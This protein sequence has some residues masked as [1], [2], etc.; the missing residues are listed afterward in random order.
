MI[1]QH[2][3]DSDEISIYVHWPYCL[4]KCP[5]CDFNSH[6]IEEINEA[7]WISAYKNEF[8]YFSEILKGKYIKSIF[9]GGGT[10]SLMPLS[11]LDSILTRISELAIIDEHTEI[12]LEANPSSVEQSKFQNIAKLGVNRISIGVQSFND[13]NLKFLGRAHSSKEAI[14]A[15]SVAQQYFSKTSFDLIY[16]LPNQTLNDWQIELEYAMQY[17][18]G[19]ISLYQLTIEKGT[20]FYKD[21]Q[22]KE[23]QLPDQSISEE[24]YIF[25]DSFLREKDIHKYEISNYSNRNKECRHNLCYWN[26][27]NYIGV[28][29]GAHSR[30]SF[31]NK[32]T[33]A[34]MMKNNPKSW[35]ESNLNSKNGIQNS[36]ILTRE[37]LLT[38]I[39]MM[40]LRLSKGMNK[41]R[42]EKLIGNNWLSLLDQKSLKMFSSMGYLQ[43]DSAA[44]MKLSDKGLLLHN[45]IVSRL[46]I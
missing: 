26:Y 5:Y 39:V 3:I 43:T 21:Y 8:E 24:M 15:I 46:F 10:P 40:G 34:I 27:D 9:F 18:A 12:T 6:K 20:K 22:N 13:N 33:Y 16:A 29:P 11:I 44:N 41:F 1:S 32:E 14:E 23:F 19:H 25:T 37:E 42:V 45:Y 28:G 2:E 38:E 7:D 4:S 17:F 30:L 36:T 31:K 35:L